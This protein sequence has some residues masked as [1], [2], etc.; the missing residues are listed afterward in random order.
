MPIIY[1]K[2]FFSTTGLEYED[3]KLIHIS[4]EKNWTGLNSL[5]YSIVT[6]DKRKYQSITVKNLHF[7]L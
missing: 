2:L 5:S 7:Q 1:H 4:F 6:I 3:L